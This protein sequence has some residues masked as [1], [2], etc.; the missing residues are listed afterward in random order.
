MRSIETAKEL[1]D[2]RVF[3]PNGL[4][5]SFAG[6]EAMKPLIWQTRKAPQFVSLDKY[7]FQFSAVSMRSIETAKELQD[8]RVFDPK[9]LKYSD[10]GYGSTKW[11]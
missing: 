3:D 1:Q 11:Q 2:M 5:F 9:G 6:S 7:I 4:K 8:M 10:A